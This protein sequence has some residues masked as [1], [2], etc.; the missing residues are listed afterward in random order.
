MALILSLIYIMNRIKN[1]SQRK[2]MVITQNALLEQRNDFENIFN[3]ILFGVI[4]LNKNNQIHLINNTALDLMQIPF[5]VKDEYAIDKP[6]NEFMEIICGRQNILPIMLNAIN[7]KDKNISIPP[8]S[9]MLIKCSNTSFPIS[10]D[11]TLIKKGPLS[12]GVDRKS[13]SAGMP[14]PK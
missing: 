9:F 14:R 10:G 13:G 5:G 6:I 3:S 12:N 7:G 4:S 8:Q 11:F 1:D 2:M